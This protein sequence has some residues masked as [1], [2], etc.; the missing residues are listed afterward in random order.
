MRRKAWKWGCFLAAGLLFLPGGARGVE[1]YAPE[2]KA[3]LRAFER[4]ELI[5]LHILADSDRPEAQR[6]KLNVRDAILRRFGDELAR[7]QSADEAFALLSDSLDEIEA[8][9]RATAAEAGSDAEARAEAGLLA[10]PEKRYGR[11]L[12][13]EG[14]YR[15]LRVTLGAGEGR[16]WWC[17]LFPQL[18][19][20]LAD[21]EPW[22]VSGPPEE[23]AALRWDSL[24]VLQ[25]WP[26]ALSLG[27]CG[28]DAAEVVNPERGEG[29]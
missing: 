26:L 28:A 16:N 20:A 5:R 11:V 15:G 29:Q 24:R 23:N 12:L 22:T 1:A 8:L 9:A 17:V 7:A 6:V 27:L 2:E 14:E 25:G 4:G 3:L 19:L 21:E 18:C 10:L 13:P